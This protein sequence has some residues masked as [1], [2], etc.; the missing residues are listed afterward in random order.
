MAKS[1]TVDGEHLGR[2]L[3]L[4]KTIHASKGATLAQLQTKLKTSRRTV[5]RDLSVLG[6]YGIHVS[7]SAKGYS[8]KQNPVACKKILGDHYVKSLNALLKDCLK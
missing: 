2:L 5:F 6:G 8:I 1:L 4:C 7:S 3:K